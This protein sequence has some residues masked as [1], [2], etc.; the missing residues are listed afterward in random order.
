MRRG[1]IP[2]CYYSSHKVIDPLEPVRHSPTEPGN[3]ARPHPACD[4]PARP[5]ERAH[6]RAEAHLPPALAAACAPHLR[7]NE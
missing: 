2:G 7:A 1:L 5:R 4:R 3:R 6:A